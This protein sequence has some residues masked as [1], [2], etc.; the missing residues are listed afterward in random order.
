MK[1]YRVT[2]TSGAENLIYADKV[3]VLNSGQIV[4]SKADE[5]IAVFN[6][7]T[8]IVCAEEDKSDY[9]NK[10]KRVFNE[11]NEGVRNIDESFMADTFLKRNSI[12]EAYEKLRRIVTVVYKTIDKAERLR[13]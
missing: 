4:L 6:K 13:I 11:M 3:E 8:D 2:T 10:L 5:V 7:E 9:E 12:E 1:L